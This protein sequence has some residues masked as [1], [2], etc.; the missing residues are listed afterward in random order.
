MTE[1][2]VA[3]ALTALIAWANSAS[4]AVQVRT[5][6]RA[7]IM[8]P[9]NQHAAINAMTDDLQRRCCNTEINNKRLPAAPAEKSGRTNA[10]CTLPTSPGFIGSVQAAFVLALIP[11]EVGSEAT[12]AASIYFHVLAYVSVVISGLVFLHKAGQSLGSL[13]RGTGS[14]VQ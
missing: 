7:A 6:P 8:T 2:S 1:S 5:A 11:F 4:A 9:S 13:L 12:V 3:V 10:A 14:G